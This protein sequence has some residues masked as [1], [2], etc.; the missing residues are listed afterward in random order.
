M[1]HSYLVSQGFVQSQADNS[2]YMKITD[3][4]MT[5]VIIWVDDIITL[6]NCTTMLKRVIG[7]L[8]KRF[9]M[10]GMGKLSWFLGIEFT[11]KEG[12]IEMHQTKYIE[13][14]Q[15]LICTIANLDPLHAK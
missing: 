1:L 10:K 8:S 11:C 15:G 14:C 4:S 13:F 9:Q 2:V 5:V 12:M 6:S 3:K 7:K